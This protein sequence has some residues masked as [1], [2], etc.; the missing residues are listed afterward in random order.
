MDGMINMVESLIEVIIFKDEKE[1]KIIQKT[2]E[3]WAQA[4]ALNS[5]LLMSKFI[6]IKK[7]YYPK[8]L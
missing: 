1:P 3:W 8:I 5:L 2:K 7:K 4:E 6:R